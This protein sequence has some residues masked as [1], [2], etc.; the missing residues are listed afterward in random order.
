MLARPCRRED[1]M[2][3][4]LERRAMHWP[5]RSRSH[6]SAREGACPYLQSASV[7][8]LTQGTRYCSGRSR[9]P[10]TTCCVTS[11]ILQS[12]MSNRA[13]HWD[14]ELAEADF[15]SAHSPSIRIVIRVVAGNRLRIEAAA[16]R[17]RRSACPTKCILVG[18][19]LPYDPARTRAD[20]FI[21][22]N[23]VPTST[24][25]MQM[26]LSATCNDAA[27]RRLGG[28]GAIQLDSRG[29]GRVVAN[30]VWLCGC[31]ELCAGCFLARR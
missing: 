10:A 23:G 17:C 8:G 14:A 20:A 27:A 31:A 22:S 19:G 25:S 2:V 1:H 13:R 16:T 3:S 24:S 12:R 5:A 11:A 29:F 30:I 6:R 28:S 26:A 18:Y 4:P 15:S 21:Q 9:R 7:N